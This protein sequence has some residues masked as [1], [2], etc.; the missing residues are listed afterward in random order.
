MAARYYCLDCEAVYSNHKDHFMRCQAGCV[1]CSEHGPG[2]PCENINA[3]GRFCKDC[4]KTFYN[5]KCYDQHLS[6]GTCRQF[7]KCVRCGVIWNVNEMNRRGRNGHECEKKF[8]RTCFQYHKEGR[9][10][11]E[12]HQLRPR[13]AYRIIA[14]DFESQQIK[15]DANQ[16][17]KKKHVVN[18]ICAKIICTDCI[19]D[20]SWN[21]PLQQPCDICGDYRTR[22][23]A[24]FQFSQTP[25]DRHKQTE[26]P[27][28]D[29]T[30]WL[31]DG[32]KLDPKYKTVCYA[33]FVSFHLL[34]LS[35][36][37]FFYISRLG[38][39]I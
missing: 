38:R 26:S 6:N 9:C 14:Y 33:H 22:T 32:E 25:T 27:L 13:K 23:W 37:R 28:T 4:S 12:P 20:G 3:V 17:K 35:N 29:F 7:K 10:F 5:D 1:N 8:C 24:P 2:Y 15:Y 34:P 31:L 18:F 36:W 19:A 16:S 39:A 30:E 21:R 11:I